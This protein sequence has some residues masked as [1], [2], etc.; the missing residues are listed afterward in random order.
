MERAQLCGADKQYRPGNGFVAICTPLSDSPAERQSSWQ[1]PRLVVSCKLLSFRP[2]T[3]SN[4]APRVTELPSTHSF[5]GTV[6][7]WSE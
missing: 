7:A 5:R 4:V 6:R 3:S 2:S 1:P